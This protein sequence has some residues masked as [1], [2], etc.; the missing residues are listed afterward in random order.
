MRRSCFI[1]SFYATSAAAATAAAVLS[2][3]F[4]SGSLFFL[5]SGDSSV[6]FFLLIHFLPNCW[7]YRVSVF[8]FFF[9]SFWRGMSV[10]G[11][12]FACC[13]STYTEAMGRSSEGRDSGFA[14][15]YRAIGSGA[16]P[17]DDGRRNQW[18]R[19]MVFVV[20]SR[21]TPFFP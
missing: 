19:V 3:A 17:A 4:T 14:F 18:L 21:G 9:P 20:T 5:F 13:T 12:N 7:R 10:I 11:P 6:F 8:F 15:R 2:H 16:R 1:V